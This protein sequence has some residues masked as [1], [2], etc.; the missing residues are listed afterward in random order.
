LLRNGDYDEEGR[1][2][3]FSDCIIPAMGFIIGLLAVICIGSY[4]VYSVE[5]TMNIDNAA[6]SNITITDKFT[7]TSSG[8][9]GGSTKYYIIDD[10]NSTYLMWISG[11]I[12][13]I[14]QWRNIVIGREYGIRYSG[15][16]AT[17][18]NSRKLLF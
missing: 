15:K 5:T 1:T 11:N 8:L 2:M 9:F 18:C 10:K 3:N 17:F 7:D 6:C 4:I 12:T 13:E 16:D 14:K